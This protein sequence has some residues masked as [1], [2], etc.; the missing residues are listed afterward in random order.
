MLPLLSRA[1]S[2]PKPAPNSTLPHPSLEDAKILSLQASL[3]CGS[4]T[5][6]N[7]TTAY[8]A[9]IT[10]IDPI[11]N[12]IIALNPSA[13]IEAQVLDDER[14]SGKVRGPLHGILLLVKDNIDVIC[15]P[16]TAGANALADNIPNA[17]AFL[18]SRLRAAG[19]I[20]LGK[21]NLSEWAFYRGFSIPSGWSGLGGQTRNP[22]VLDRMP[23]G[24]S[25]GTGAAVAAS[26]CSAGVGTDTFGSIVNPSSV[27]G[28][29]GIKPTPGLISR[30]CII[31]LSEAQDT[32]GPMARTVSDAAIL[33]QAMA[34]FDAKDKAA[35]TTHGKEVDYTTYLT[36]DAVKDVCIGVL[37]EPLIGFGAEIDGVFE[38]ALDKLRRAGAVMVDVELPDPFRWFSDVQTAFRCEFRT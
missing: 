20:I 15:L 35:R 38:D 10:A 26:L 12:S 25:S 13:T 7:L 3:T 11:I 33:L 16:T 1:S 34:G 37:R 9:R 18:V 23:G 17:D 6:L 30:T 22:Y 28:L 32:A 31:P 21:T 2:C 5:S 24:S 29:V 36:E 4:L 19:A 8:L 27:N 14:A